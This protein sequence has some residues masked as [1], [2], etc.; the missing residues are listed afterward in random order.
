[1]QPK[2]SVGGSVIVPVTLKSTGLYFSLIAR[3]IWEMNLLLQDV[4]LLESWLEKHS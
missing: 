2:C 1:M 3:G 4:C